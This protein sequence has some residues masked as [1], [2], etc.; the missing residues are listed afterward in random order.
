[1]LSAISRHAVNGKERERALDLQLRIRAVFPRTLIDRLTVVGE[2]PMPALGIDCF[3]MQ[4]PAGKSPE[5]LAELIAG[6]DARI[7]AALAR[8]EAASHRARGTPAGEH[9]ALKERHERLRAAVQDGSPGI[10]PF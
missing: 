5:Q 6:I 9:E 8:I 7:E 3:V 10:F 2:W 4:I 1:M